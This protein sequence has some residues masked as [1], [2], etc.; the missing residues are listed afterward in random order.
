MRRVACLWLFLGAVCWS[1]NPYANTLVLVSIDGFRWDFLDLPE[2]S[3]MSA[4]A[5]RG[6]R[7][8]KLRTVYPSKTFP[9]HLSI[10]TGLYPTGHGVVDNRFCRSNRADCYRMGHG[11][12]DP[13]WLAGTPLWTLV[14]Q[15][16]GRA[17]TFFWPE[18]DA[19]FAGT[20]PTDYRLYD[21][22]V[23]HGKRVAQV[24]EWLSLPQG[25]RPDLVTLYFS[26]VDSAGHTF[27]PESKETRAAIAEI[28]EQIATLW[29]S[30]QSLN[31]NADAQISLLLLSD[32]GMAEVDPATF[33]DTNDL[34]RP[35][36]F[37]RMNGSTRV[38][39]YQRDPEADLAALASELDELADGRFWRVTPDMLAE[40]HF[41]DHPAV[42]QI[43]VETAP[44]RVFR[45][46]GGTRADLRGMHGYPD[47]VE[48]M[49]AFLV[50]VGPGFHSGL[51]IPEAHQ[52]DVYPVAARLLA[53][54]APVDLASDGGHL[55][56]A[57]REQ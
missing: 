47:D 29:R 16:G 41:V 8:T 46:G 23:P 14:E 28:D 4:I 20:L 10:A 37:K 22:R 44:P 5:S 19:P 2:A 57:L 45:H 3:Q 17:S 27:G 26:A 55:V 42:G 15:Q 11:R 50:A 25:T 35:Q 56:R 31:V 21:G 34:P 13:T 9:A 18:S 30:I 1:A 40:R 24:V 54:K 7:V 43:I 53:L 38:T 36:G 33:I 49:A 6:T 32:H 39:Y 52:L 48:D 12:K 51:V